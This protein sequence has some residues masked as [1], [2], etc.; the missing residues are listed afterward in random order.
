[1]NRDLTKE[2]ISVA[3]TQQMFKITGKVQSKIVRYYDT[4]TRT[5]KM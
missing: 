1:M 4:P 3:N 2:D 5:A